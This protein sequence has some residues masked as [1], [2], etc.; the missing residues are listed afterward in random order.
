MVW[1]A[2]ENFS[3][4]E[5]RKFRSRFRALSLLSLFSVG[6]VGLD[7]SELLELAGPSFVREEREKLYDPRNAPA[8]R[9]FLGRALYELQEKGLVYFKATKYFHGRKLE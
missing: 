7:F 8:T 9:A 6:G 1:Q 3:L 2:C 4:E 5:Q